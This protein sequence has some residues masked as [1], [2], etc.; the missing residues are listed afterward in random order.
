M[1][2]ISVVIF[3]WILVFADCNK[4]DIAKSLLE[5]RIYNGI[6]TME[7][8]LRIMNELEQAYKN[9]TAPVPVQMPPFPCRPTGRSPTVPTNARRVKAED[10][11]IVMAMGDSIVTGALALNPLLPPWDGF[12]KRAY[13]F[14][15]GSDGDPTCETLP[16]SLKVFNPNVDG[17]SIGS[18]DENSP[19]ARLNVAVDGATSETLGQQIDPL[20]NKLNS[21][22]R[23][24][25]KLLSIFIGGND[26][27]NSCADADP[28]RYS[29][30]RYRA[31]LEA[32]LDRIKA[33]IPRCFVSL[34][35]PPDITILNLLSGG[36][37]SIFA[38]FLCSC[39]TNG[40]PTKLLHGQYSKIL[41]EIEALPKYDDKEDFYLSVQPFFE[42]IQ[43]PTLPDGKP[44]KSYFAIDC[45][46]LSWS[47]HYAAGQGYWNNLMEAKKDKDRKWVVGEPWLCPNPDLPYLQ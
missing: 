32:V 22:P 20:L 42:S 29:P 12:D 5:S 26:L 19:N 44:D 37:C 35:T 31:N 1:R 39:K 11:D 8:A 27:C 16:S 33:N 43:L 10:I 41:H 7:D 4:S 38:P 24:S 34:I 13:S 46:H 40:E 15:G 36:S 45:F 23:D 3:C 21:Y 47:G 9:Y 6:K 14:C 18:G 30:A 28:N 2:V 17:Y 25:W